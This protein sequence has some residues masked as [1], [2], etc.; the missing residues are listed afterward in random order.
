MVENIESV[1]N[2]FLKENIP[3]DY[4]TENN[5]VKVRLIENSSF[6]EIDYYTAWYNEYNEKAQIPIFSI[7]SNSDFSQYLFKLKLLSKDIGVNGT[8]YWDLDSL[9]NNSAI[10]PNL[11]HIEFALNNSNHHKK[12]ITYQDDYDENGG[13]GLLLDKCAN[14][15]KLRIPSAPNH[16]FFERTNH[17]LEELIVQCGYDHQNFIEN[18][19]NSTC[20]STLKKLNFTDYSEIYMRDYVQYSVPFKSYL[21]LLSSNT[22]PSLKKIILQNTQL[23]L[24]QKDDLEVISLYKNIDLTLISSI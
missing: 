6:F 2:T 3:H 20:F 18:L 8:Q 16:Y 24:D 15:K 17:S 19:A 5:H 11:T 1:I 12:I 23:T 10:F 9:I 13:I 14:L 21:K 22:L 4:S 7:L